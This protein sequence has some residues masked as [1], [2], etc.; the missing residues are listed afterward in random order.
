MKEKL[1]II[2]F[3]LILFQ[4]SSASARWIDFGEWFGGSDL[5]VNDSNYNVNTC[6]MPVP[7]PTP[8]GP[9]ENRSS[10]PYYLAGPSGVECNYYSSTGACC[11]RGSVWVP[12]APTNVRIRPIDN[13]Y[14]GLLWDEDSIPNS[15]QRYLIYFNKNN[16]STS[17]KDNI[18]Y[19]TYKD[20]MKSY[21]WGTLAPALKSGD[22]LYVVIRAVGKYGNT[23]TN[24]I[25]I[26]RN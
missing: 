23:S 24:K 20:R 17:L 6:G 3:A 15:V 1:S 19:Q 22:T 5:C 10:A 25:R 16:S 14:S 8:V 18:T 7:I 2:F 9:G 26:R 11:C 21:N 13:Q 12:N 4:S